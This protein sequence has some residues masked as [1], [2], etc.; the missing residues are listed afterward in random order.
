MAQSQITD[1]RKY[2]RPGHALTSSLVA[3]V[4]KAGVAAAVMEITRA[5]V[6]QPAPFAIG[7]VRAALEV[8][9]SHPPVA[10]HDAVAAVREGTRVTVP[11]GFPT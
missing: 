2:A 11:E 5:G 8:L 9:A 7:A 10:A 6:N 4:A 3:C 1:E